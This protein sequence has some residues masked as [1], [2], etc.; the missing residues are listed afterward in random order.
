[1]STIESSILVRPIWKIDLNHTA[2]IVTSTPEAKRIAIASEAS[3]IS[4]AEFGQS[5]VQ[6]INLSEPTRDL[7]INSAGN[8]LAV[9]GASRKL[10]VLGF[11]SSNFKRE[12][13]RW[14]TPVYDTCTFSRDGDLLW[15][16][17]GLSDHVAEIHCYDARNWKLLDQLQ[18]EP[19][20]D[21]CGF[22]L[23]LHP[24]DDL[25]GLWACGGDRRSQTGRLR[26]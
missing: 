7:S 1:M 22:I 4:V 5:S 17:G 10:Q 20:I 23:T 13:A 12:V 24:Q 16:V 25:V 21:G 18:F 2:T 15:T 26:T 19:H 6:T 3:I 11:E 8:N 14:E 9:V